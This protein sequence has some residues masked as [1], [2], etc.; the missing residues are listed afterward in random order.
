MRIMDW[1]LRLAWNMKQQSLQHTESEMEDD[2][3]KL[4]GYL[5]RAQAHANRQAL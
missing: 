1:D 3:Q 2:L 4:K 5:A